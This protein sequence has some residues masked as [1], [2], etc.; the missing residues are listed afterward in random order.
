[1]DKVTGKQIIQ[2]VESRIV[3]MENADLSQSVGA[4]NGI[5]MK[6]Y[7]NGYLDALRQLKG[8]FETRV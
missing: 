6:T 3:G 8:F 2:E 4:I 5:D 7:S 1:M